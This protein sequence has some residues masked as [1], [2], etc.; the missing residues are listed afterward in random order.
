M[1]NGRRSISKELA[2]RISEKFEI[3]YR[4]FITHHYAGHRSNFHCQFGWIWGKT[5]S[6]SLK[7]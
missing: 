3:D 1:E 2:K 7:S 4:I 6:S 5:P